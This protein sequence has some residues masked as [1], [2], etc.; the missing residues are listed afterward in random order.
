MLS[1]VIKKLDFAEMDSA[2]VVHRAAFDDRLPWLAGL[3]TP[4][5]DRF[6]FR[7][8]VFHKCEVWGALD[9]ARLIGIIAFREGWIDHLYVLPGAQSQGI[10]TALLDIAKGAFSPLQLWT[11][12]RNLQARTFYEARG[13]V[14]IKETDGS[15]NDEKEPDALYLW[16]RESGEAA[17]NYR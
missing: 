10:G 14:L 8:Q 12:Q 13:F 15:A 9:T 2:A 6:Y 4:A 16:S 1:L 5:E 3:H 11:F 17:T 7:E